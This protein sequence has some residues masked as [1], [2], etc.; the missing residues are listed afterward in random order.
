MSKSKSELVLG[1]VS[2]NLRRKGTRVPRKKR[3]CIGF[4]A[5]L[6]NMKA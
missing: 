4:E 5:E 2:E 3:K 6:E 1:K